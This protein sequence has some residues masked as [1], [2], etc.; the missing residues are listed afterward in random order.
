MGW[1]DGRVARRPAVALALSGID[2]VATL[3]EVA[4]WATGITRLHP[5]VDEPCEG[6]CEIPVQH[7]LSRP[8]ATGFPSRSRCMAAQSG[9]EAGGLRV[10]ERGRWTVQGELVRWALA[11]LIQ[12]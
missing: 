10:L 8:G 9:R 12:Q 5:A 2:A 7:S 6:C 4:E 1:D 11:A 3:S